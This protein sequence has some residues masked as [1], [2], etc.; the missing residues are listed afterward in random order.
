MKEIEDEQ[1]AAFVNQRILIERLIIAELYE[2]AKDIS[3]KYVQMAA[4]F[5]N[6]WNYGNAI[7]YGNMYKGL[8]VLKENSIKE[9]AISLIESA[10]TPGSPQ[11]NSFGPNTLLADKMYKLG[12]VAE[13]KEFLELCRLFWLLGSSKI[14]EWVEAID[15][16]QP[17]NFAS[18]FLY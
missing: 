6:H 16:N 5:Q 10:K 3:T 9:A 12:R 11:L 17:P 14:D 13:V 4:K 1:E 2:E 15:S 18:H 8:L 7:Y